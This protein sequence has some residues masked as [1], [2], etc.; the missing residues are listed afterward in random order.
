MTTAEL[1]QRL[2]VFL[3]KRSLAEANESGREYLQ[4]AC[5][6]INAGAQELFRFAP[7]TVTNREIGFVC[8]PPQ[9]VT[10]TDATPYQNT[11]VVA[12]WEPWMLHQSA[13]TYGEF[14]NRV[15]SFTDP[16][17]TFQNQ[18]VPPGPILAE[19][20][21]DTLPLPENTAKVLGPV[22]L[23]D[24]YELYPATTEGELYGN[25][26][27]REVRDYGFRNLSRLRTRPPAPGNPRSYIVTTFVPNNGPS[28]LLHLRLAPWPLTSHQVR[29][30]LRMAPPKATV[31]DLYALTNG[32]GATQE[33]PIPAAWDET[34]L[35]PIALK[36]LTRSPFWASPGAAQEID[37]AYQV[38]ISTLAEANPQESRPL[39]IYPGV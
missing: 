37:R 36:H 21:N 35:M 1:A 26:P 12:G 27:W 13:M 25:T 19:I 6:A 4:S 15:E 16:Q 7:A 32:V 5:D 9:Q 8:R 39:H 34:Y 2:L 17:A 24:V 20:Y 38:T 23:D 3:D 29:V 14:A 18:F 11:A 33:I 28:P 31:A 22:T 30:K 10:L